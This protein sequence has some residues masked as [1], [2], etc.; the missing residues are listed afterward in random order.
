MFIFAKNLGIGLVTIAR[1]DSGDHRDWGCS[2]GARVEAGRRG[3][4]HQ[5]S[6]DGAK[7]LEDNLGWRGLEILGGVVTVKVRGQ[8]HSPGVLGAG[9][10]GGQS[11]AEGQCDKSLK[12]N[13]Y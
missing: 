10:A 4:R 13:F 6:V 11:K 7:A 5:R 3:C 9:E 8:P 1:E 2:L 12:W